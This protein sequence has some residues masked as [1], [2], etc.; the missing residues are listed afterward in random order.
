[1]TA[2]KAIKVYLIAVRVLFILLFAFL[3]YLIPFFVYTE[4]Y[5]E[6]Y[7]YESGIPFTFGEYLLLYPTEVALPIALLMALPGFIF[8]WK[9]GW[10]AGLAIVVAATIGFIQGKW[11]SLIPLFGVAIYFLLIGMFV[12][13]RGHFEIRLKH[14][15]WTIALLAVYAGLLVIERNGGFLARPLPA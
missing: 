11:G 12:Q 13:L 2:E 14:L 15:L 6:S 10:I 1:M 7:Y 4:G 5:Q 3:L 8:R 9:I